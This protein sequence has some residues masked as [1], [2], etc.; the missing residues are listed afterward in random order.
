M[1]DIAIVLACKFLLFV[2][3]LVESWER[4]ARSAAERLAWRAVRLSR[5]HTKAWRDRHEE[6]RRSRIAGL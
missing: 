4:F 5:H 6:E 2:A 3:G 1:R